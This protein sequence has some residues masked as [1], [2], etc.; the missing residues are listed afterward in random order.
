A[1]G[2]LP[3]GRR[4][5]GIGSVGRRG[6]VR[7]ALAGI[8]LLMAAVTVGGAVMGGASTNRHNLPTC[9]SR[10]SGI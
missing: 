10:P 1:A 9:S 8:G 2:L 4:Q 3:P 5:P 6:G 7:F